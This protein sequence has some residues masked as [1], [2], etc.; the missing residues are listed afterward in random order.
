MSSHLVRVLVR[1]TVALSSSVVLALPVLL[2]AG[3]LAPLRAQLVTPKTVPVHNAQQFDV[4][5]SANAAMGGVSI[6]LDDSLLDAFVNPAKGARIRQG[7][8]FTTPFSHSVSNAR[9]GGRTLPIGGNV[10]VGPWTF[11][12]VF[13]IQQLDRSGPMRWT[14]VISDRSAMNQYVTTAISRRLREGLSIGLTSSWGDLGAVDGV[15][16]M[17]ATSDRITQSGDF[18]DLRVGLLKEWNDSRSFELLVLHNRFAMTHD[19]HY[20]TWRWDTVGRRPV[21]VERTD[22]NDDRSEVWGAHARYVAPYGTEG[23]RFGWIGTVNKLWH[24]KIPTYVLEGS[25]PIPRDPG[26][27]T[28]FNLGVGIG[29][30]R[31]G[32]TFGADFILEP[33]RT[34]TWADAAKDTSV[35]GGPVIR[36]GAKTMENSFRFSNVRMRLG[37]SHDVAADSSAGRI[38]G[39][40][41]GLDVYSINYRLGQTDNVRK[42]FRTQR[43]S[44]VEWG[45]AFGFRYQARQF[46]AQY[47]FTWTCS[48]TSCIG[49]GDR[50]MV[51]SPSPL[52]AASAPVVFAPTAALTFDGGTVKTHR[53]SVSVPIR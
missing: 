23:W 19:V 48:A 53:I 28:G 26:H 4:F 9:G 52:E 36:S 32:T 20:Q 15:D 30:T 21:S 12:G 39:F 33:I 31:G 14:N 10:P 22:R 6:A 16:L 38:F 40:Q 44:W 3:G 46:R 11:S 5:P 51:T 13:A 1:R 2:G 25:F 45:P 50:V 42:T 35:A 29:R 47:T 27:T 17:Y 43:E 37:L 8:F 34:E 7:R 24:P 49:A 18:S 41:L